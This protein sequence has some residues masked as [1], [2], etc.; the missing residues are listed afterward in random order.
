M[1]IELTLHTV[2]I[3]NVSIESAH[4]FPDACSK[5]LKVGSADVTSGTDCG[6]ICRQY[7]LS[8]RRTF[9]TPGKFSILLKSDV[10]QANEEVGCSS[11][12][13]LPALCRLRTHFMEN[14]NNLFPNTS[15][16]SDSSPQG[17]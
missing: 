15:L 3:Y 4:D 6:Q 10:D 7:G 1:Y 16:S 5:I 14:L 12:N 8:P 17:F 2:T 9:L 11:E 13:Q